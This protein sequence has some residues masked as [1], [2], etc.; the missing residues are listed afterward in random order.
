[1]SSVLTSPGSGPALSGTEK[2]FGTRLVT[3]T[4]GGL[5]KGWRRKE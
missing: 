4:N 5:E 2:T 1:M 3:E